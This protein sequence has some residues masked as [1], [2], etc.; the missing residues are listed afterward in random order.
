VLCDSD[1]KMNVSLAS[2][3]CILV[4]VL[5]ALG[6]K[7]MWVGGGGGDVL[8]FIASCITVMES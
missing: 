5:G 1:G 7:Q 3:V 6:V 2:E 4:W 8:A